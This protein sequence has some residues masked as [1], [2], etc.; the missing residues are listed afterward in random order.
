M[1]NSVYPKAKEA[2]LPAGLNLM[3]GTVKVQLI[4]LANYTYSAA[5]QYLSDIPSLARVGAPVTLTG[6]SITNGVFDA[7]DPTWSG[8][9]GAP[10]IE[11][12]IIYVDTGVEGSSPLVHYRDTDPG[13]PVAAGATGG[14]VTWDNGANKIFAV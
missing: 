12:L 2:M 7:A 9:T 1:T 6:K 5:H 11:A 4:D 14:T 8:L 10:S 3:T 13:L